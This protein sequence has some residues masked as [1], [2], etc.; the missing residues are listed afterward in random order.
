MRTAVGSVLVSLLVLAT[1]CSTAPKTQAEKKSLVAEA[2]ATLSTMIAKDSSL[3][4]FV[5][6]SHGYAVFPDVGKAGLIAGGA[7]GRGVVF[8]ENARPVGFA[9]LNQASVGAQIGGQSYSE[10]VVFENEAALNR[11]K[12]GNF[13]VGA[14]VSAVALKA[15]AAG[16][17]RFEGGVAVF[18]LPKGGLM[19]AAA[20]NGQKINFEPM[21]QSVTAGGN[22]GTSGTSSTRPSRSNTAS[23]DDEMQLRTERISDSPGDRTAETRTTE[24]RTGDAAD[25]AQNAT[26][27]TQARIEQ[28][29]EQSQERQQ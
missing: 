17:A 21:D 20:I 15:G 13:D 18:Q 12:A 4:D 24:T 11:L 25:S 23:D 2:D 29:L 10:L 16:A 22:S 14:E 7:Y 6:N 26:D 5:D 28:R 27:R 3:R 1:G 9:E 19:A 8:D